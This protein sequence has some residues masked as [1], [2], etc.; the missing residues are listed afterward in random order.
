VA[1]RKLAGPQQAVERRNPRAGL[2]AAEWV[3]QFPWEGGSDLAAVWEWA[4]ASRAAEQWELADCLQAGPWLALA[5]SE[6]GA[7]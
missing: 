6:P 7:R 1:L 4:A 2:E 5:Q 3:A